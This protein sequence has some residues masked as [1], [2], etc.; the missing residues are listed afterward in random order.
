MRTLFAFL[1][2][3]LVATRVAAADECDTTYS[4]ACRIVGADA[5]GLELVITVPKISVFENQDA[6][7]RD[8]C[9]IPRPGNTDDVEWL[10]EGTAIDVKIFRDRDGQRFLDAK[11][12]LT[13]HAPPSP[14]SNVAVRL[15]TRFVPDWVWQPVE[16]EP[17]GVRLVSTGAR[18]I[19]PLK[20]GE[21][22]VVPFGQHGWQ[23]LEMRV[24]ELVPQDRMATRPGL[25]LGGVTPRII[26]QEEEEE[27]LGIPLP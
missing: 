17:T 20:L 19:E 8:V 6:S 24:N 3:M 5:N 15:L 18:V 13:G 22:L 16:E 12:T 14:V 7:I 26:V 1:A 23:R 4:I 10:E 25:I 21:K 2:C 11:L 9:Q 27:R